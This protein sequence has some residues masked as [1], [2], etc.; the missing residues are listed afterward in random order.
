VKIERERPDSVIRMISSLLTRY[1]VSVSCSPDY[2]QISVYEQ[3]ADAPDRP[4]ALM[5]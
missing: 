2:Y 1:C 4:L 5:A 3:R